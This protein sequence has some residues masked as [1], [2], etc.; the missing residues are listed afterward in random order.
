MKYK[1]I[2]P[3]LVEAT[4]RILPPTLKK[5]IRAGLE[6]IKENPHMG[7]TLKDELKGLWSYRVNRYRIVYRIEHSRIE[8]QVIDLSPRAIIYQ[9]ILAWTKRIQE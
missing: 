9:R 4:I 6:A 7:K 1:V 8:V 3:P 2:V 5:M